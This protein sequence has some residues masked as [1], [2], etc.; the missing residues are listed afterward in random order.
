M[1]LLQVTEWKFFLARCAIHRFSQISF[2]IHLL[3]LS[4]IKL[5]IIFL[6]DL[7]SRCPRTN[8]NCRRLVPLNTIFTLF[9][10]KLPGLVA[11]C[12]VALKDFSDKQQTRFTSKLRD[13]RTK[14]FQILMIFIH[15]LQPFLFR[16]CNKT[17]FICLLA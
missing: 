10:L 13:F 4:D 5:F 12:L 3:F 7:S 15:T 17:K 2:T 11:A 8:R 14:M 6:L 16:Y 9:G 1:G